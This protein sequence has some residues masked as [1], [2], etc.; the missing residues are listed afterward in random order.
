MPARLHPQ[1][2]IVGRHDAEL[3]ATADATPG[4]ADDLR[5]DCS[6][7]PLTFDDIR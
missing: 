7:L 1:L 4:Y 3:F 5:P 2:R 6:L